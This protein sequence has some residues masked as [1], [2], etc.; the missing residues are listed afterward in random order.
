MGALSCGFDH[1]V[2]MRD[3]AD[4]QTQADLK[5][6]LAKLVSEDK[7]ENRGGTYVMKKKP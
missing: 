3:G 1:N 5:K 2:H 7:L 4:D 6:F